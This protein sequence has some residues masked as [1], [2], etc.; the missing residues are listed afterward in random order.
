RVTATGLSMGGAGCWDW[1]MSYPED[2]AGIAP[3]C[4]YGRTL[5]VA[6]MRAIPV[7]AYH[8]SDDTVVRPDEQRALVEAL[9][10]G[11]GQAELTI[12]P[13]V[14]HDAWTPAFADPG[15]VPWLLARQR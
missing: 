13:G 15:L 14:G 4:G 9:R 3:V 5:R 10:M 7:R 8:G 6:R 1:A 2:L 12:Y 11:G